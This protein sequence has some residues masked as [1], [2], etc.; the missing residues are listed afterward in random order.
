MEKGEGWV[1]LDAWGTLD[2]CVC[3]CVR[4]RKRERERESSLTL[5][6]EN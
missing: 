2:E 1:R 3:V 4:D 6:L 5:V